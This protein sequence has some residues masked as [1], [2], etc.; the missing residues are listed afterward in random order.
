MSWKIGKQILSPAQAYMFL[1]PFFRKH[2]NTQEAIFII[3][4]DVKMRP[5]G[6]PWMASLG[7]V[8]KTWAHPRD[9]FREAIKRNAYSIIISHNHPSGDHHPSID[10]IN[11]TNKLKDVGAIIDIS[12]TDHI[13]ISRN[14]FE[15][16]KGF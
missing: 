9:I 10:D 6:K 8:S 12:I 1:K 5:I 2:M 15:S 4:L 7:T 11:L 13:V 3:A 16:I 14:G